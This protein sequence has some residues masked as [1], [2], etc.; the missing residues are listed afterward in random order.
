[1]PPRREKA[2]LA[3]SR[4]NLKGHFV[5]NGDKRALRAFRGKGSLRP[6]KRRQEPPAAVVWG[7]KPGE[8]S[9]MTHL[10]VLFSTTQLRL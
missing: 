6:G 2:V 9:S 4:A 10:L 1:M 5:K 7:R 8:L 3:H